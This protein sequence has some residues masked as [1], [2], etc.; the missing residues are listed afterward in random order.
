MKMIGISAKLPDLLDTTA[1]FSNPSIFL[2]I[3]R[4]HQDSDLGLNLPDQ[5]QRRSRRC[6]PPR[7]SIPA[8][9]EDVGDNRLNVSGASSTAREW[10]R[11]AL[12]TQNNMEHQGLDCVFVAVKVAVFGEAA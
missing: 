8:F 11:R 4:V 3:N 9:F 10:S 7:S 5:G 12:R 1:K 6:V 2:A